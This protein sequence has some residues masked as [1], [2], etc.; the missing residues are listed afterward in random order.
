M[1]M[2][3]VA[4]GRACAHMAQPLAVSWLVRPTAAA[5]AACSWARAAA[6][7]LP[8]AAVLARPLAAGGAC[9]A[10]TMGMIGALDLQDPCA[11]AQPC[12]PAMLSICSCLHTAQRPTLS[13]DTTWCAVLWGRHDKRTK[14][15]KRYIGDFSLERAW[16][17]SSLVLLSE[18]SPV[19]RSHTEF[20]QAL[21]G[22]SGRANRKRRPS[23]RSSGAGN[24]DGPRLVVA[25]A[26]RRV[27]TH[28]CEM[29]L[30]NAFWRP[31]RCGDNRE[32]GELSGGDNHEYGELSGMNGCVG[33]ITG[34][35]GV[36][37]AH[38]ESFRGV[39]GERMLLPPPLS[40]PGGSSALTRVRCG[41][42]H[43]SRR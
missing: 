7:L 8:S 10:A 11:P 31:L 39:S 30:G 38:I 36:S 20:V 24:S 12:C 43:P 25:S 22:R 14:K 33:H 34:I 37:K 35:C 15:G 5:A 28:D 27:P 4:G 2:A 19:A 42:K 3:A 6:A 32:Y 1:T 40:P 17:A 18:E 41:S 16:R 9:G 23:H 26:P 29:C 13:K 21:G